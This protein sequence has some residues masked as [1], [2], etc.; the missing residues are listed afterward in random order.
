MSVISRRQL[1]AATGV[2]AAAGVGAVAAVAAPRSKH[3]SGPAP[4][5]SPLASNSP[6][7]VQLNAALDREHALISGLDAVLLAD[8]NAHPALANIRADHVAHADAISAT[9]AVAA[10]H[11]APTPTS[12]I[13][14]TAPTS[15]APTLAALTSAE[16]AAQQ[17]AAQDSAQLT[18]PDAALLA[19]ISACEA[20][21]VEL[22]I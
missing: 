13:S 6:A 7:A 11:P 10:G 1:L 14:P 22:L 20:G 3:N 9:I 21:H 5:P 4:A 17:A 8:A 2:L 18:G 12:A 16:Q 19:A 15:S